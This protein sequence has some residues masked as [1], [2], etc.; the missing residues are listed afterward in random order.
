M[1]NKENYVSWS[2]RLLR[3]AKSRPNGKLIHNSILNGPYVRKM[4]PAGDANCEITV[5]ETF[6]L[7][8]DD[9]LSDKELKQIEAGLADAIVVPTITADNFKLKHGLLTLV[10]NKQLFGHDKEDMHAHIHYFNKITSTLKFPNVPNTSIKLMLFP[11]SLEG[12]TQIWLE[13]EPPRSILTWD[14]L[15]SKFIKQFFPL[16]QTTSL[17][18]EITNFQQ[19]FDE[20]FN[21]D[22]LNSAARGNFLDKMPRDCLSIIEINSKVCYSR[23]KPVVARVS[24]NS[25]TSGV[26]PDVA[27]LKDMVK[28][29]LLDKKVQNQ[30]PA[31]VKA[32]EESCVTCGG[33]RMW[34]TGWGR[35]SHVPIKVTDNVASS[36]YV[37]GRSSDVNTLGLACCVELMEDDMVQRF[38]EKSDAGSSNNFTREIYSQNHVRTIPE[39][40]MGEKGS[41]ATKLMLNLATVIKVKNRR[42]KEMERKYMETKNTIS[43]LIVENDNL[44][45]SFYEGKGNQFNIRENFQW[46]CNDHEIVNLKLKIQEKELELRSAELQKREVV[47]QK[48]RKRLAKEI[49][50]V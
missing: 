26:S 24:T 34:S 7:Q 23:D 29:L 13:K 48:K 27:E 22:S 14:D 41:K 36:V 38:G 47:N 50:K 16:S 21:Q 25:S 11:F 2:S 1:L 4:I 44:Q 43:K 12:A 37:N 31:P 9:E 30:S 33:H 46:I 5:I 20:S 10:Q 8:T 35:V 32:V 42:F 18:N 19:R 17:R 6:H 3:Y 15:V 28:A 45:Q 39:I 40:I 49:E